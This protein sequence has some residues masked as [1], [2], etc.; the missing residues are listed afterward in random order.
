MSTYLVLSQHLRQEVEGG[1]TGPSAVT[2][3]SGEAARYV[4]WI[5]DAYTELQQRREW[6]W[7]R[8][9]FSVNT[10]ADDDSYAGTDCTDTRL[11]ASVT[12]F[13]RWITHDDCGYSNI[14]AYLQSGGVSGEYWLTPLSWAEFRNIYKIGSQTSGQPHHFAI[15]PQNNLRLGPKPSAVYVVTGEYQMSPQILAA[16]GDTPEMPSQFHE[17]TVYE[18]MEKYGASSIAPEV[19]ARAQNEGGRMRNALMRNQLPKVSFGSPLA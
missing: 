10:V 17:L 18:A 6:N 15:D 1:G 4:K 16:D 11:S 5:A 13:S 7:L 19:L 14:K 8:S 2:G 12:R 3:Q 9:E